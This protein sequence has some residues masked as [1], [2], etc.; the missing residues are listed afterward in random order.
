[1]GDEH[2]SQSGALWV[3]GVMSLITHQRFNNNQDDVLQPY[4][5][6]AFLHVL[7]CVK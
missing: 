3:P 7:E 2:L 6:D 1:V 5:K 4:E